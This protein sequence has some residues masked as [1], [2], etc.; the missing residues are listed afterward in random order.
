MSIKILMD[1]HNFEQEPELTFE[2][3]KQ[4]IHT[5][6]TEL[7]ALE[8]RVSDFFSLNII[9]R[10]KGIFKLNSKTMLQ[11]TLLSQLEILKDNIE[12]NIYPIISI[13]H[14]SPD[15]LKAYEQTVI[16]KN[17]K[18]K[19]YFNESKLINI[20]TK[21]E[22]YLNGF[23]K[24]KK[25]LEALI[26][27][28][29]TDTTDEKSL[30][31]KQLLIYNYVSELTAVVNYFMET[32]TAIADLS[33]NDDDVK[34]SYYATEELITKTIYENAEHFI[35]SIN[36]DIKDVLKEFNNA[37]EPGLTSSVFEAINAGLSIFD[38]IPGVFKRF[39]GN[40]FYELGKMW[41]NYQLA[42]AEKCREQKS[43]F[44]GLVIQKQAELNKEPSNKLAKQQLEYYSNM[45]AE[46]DDKIKKYERI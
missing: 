45:I 31:F 28:N 41:N 7:L 40:P 19:N 22:H 24:N 43:F 21:T 8:S 5:Q 29:I 10:L 26:K 3:Y 27:T 18:N 4:G 32:M 23:I 37:K 15:I 6:N 2:Q 39:T 17:L 16:F 34:L 25:E 9:G 20:V 12:E 1:A 35:T 46:L 11:T 42:Q 13:C 36:T 33:V 38:F 30:T 44:E 14:N